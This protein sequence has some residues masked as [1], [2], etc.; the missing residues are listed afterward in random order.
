[1]QS[2]AVR[3]DASLGRVQRIVDG[4]LTFARAG[5]Q[6][7]SDARAEVRP[8]VAGLLEE[9]S[10]EARRAGAVLAI[11]G[12][13]PVCGVRCSEGVLLSI[14]S[15]LL[16]NALKYLGTAQTREVTLAVTM[17]DD[18]VLF[19]VADTGPGVP[20]ESREHIFAPYVRAAASQGV[21]GIGLGLAT[22][23]RLAASH[24]GR[25]GYRPRSTGGSVF[26]FELPA[27]KHATVL[28]AARGEVN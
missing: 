3:A 4:L 9:L 13:V 23:Q 18:R 2:A 7:P 22:V 10:E 25:A 21:P 19:E 16:R 27:A 14:L 28:A 11:A 5:A 26:W 17:R 8:L 6:A 20:A 15:N 12:D 24:G 1:V